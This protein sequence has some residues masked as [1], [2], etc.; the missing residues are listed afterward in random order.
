MNY[1][2]NTRNT[3]DTIY[4]ALQDEESRKLFDAR[5]RYMVD[6]NEGAYIETIFELNQLY[7]KKWHC[8][9]IEKALGD[10]QEIIIYG[11][12]HYGRMIK[13]NLEICGYSIVCWCDS[14]SALWGY[15]VEGNIVL[16]PEELM[17]NY[18]NCLVIISSKNYETEMRARLMD[19]EFPIKNVF[20]F[21]YR[22]G[23]SVCGDQYFDV[24]QPKDKEIFIDA[25]AYKGDSIE[26]FLKWN[27]GAYKAYSL[28]PSVDMCAIMERKGI[29][30]VQIINCAAW[31]TEENLFFNDAS[32]GGNVESVGTN[33]VCGKSIDV[34]LNG[35]E[36]TFIKM[37][38]EGA[39]LDAL[40]GAKQTI[41]KYKPRL[42]IC[43]YPKYD[44]ILQIGKYIL[45]L[46]PEYK[47]CIR[48]YTTY[49]WET[50]LY[51]W[52]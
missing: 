40:K 15:E 26:K 14:N 1:W 49:M 8:P 46:N 11:C 39:E 27:R 37:D 3:L 12:G 51:A 30:S 4:S 10:R 25:G 28:E 24:F 44:D 23:I 50:V 21:I 22:Q 17:P 5:V 18:A 19:V 32:R 20:V 47:F 16:S 34:I 2:K 41:K 9:E 7:P 42:A 48:H 45:D 38:I 31:S 43:I 13:R 35:E 36:A 52:I 6:R 29:P 33:V